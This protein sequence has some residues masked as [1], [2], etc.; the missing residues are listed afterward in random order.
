MLVT[1]FLVLA[2]VCWAIALIRRS[3]AVAA[4]PVAWLGF[5]YFILGVLFVALGAA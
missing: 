5:G 3:D 4:V 1:I 2:F